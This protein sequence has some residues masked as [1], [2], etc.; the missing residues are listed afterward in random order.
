MAKKTLQSSPPSRIQPIKE[1]KCSW[2]KCKE[3]SEVLLPHPNDNQI[4]IGLCDK[5]WGK[6]CELETNEGKKEWKEKH[7]HMKIREPK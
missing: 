5:H 3:D 4:R 6:Y 7:F 1:N 2:E